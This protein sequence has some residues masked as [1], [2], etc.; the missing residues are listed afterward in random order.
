MNT[1]EGC[2]VHARVLGIG[3]ALESYH[4]LICITLTT[5]FLDN[6]AFDEQT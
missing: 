6:I 1:P 4:K 2:K 3:T 5:F